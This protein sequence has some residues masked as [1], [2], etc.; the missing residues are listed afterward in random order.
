M[1]VQGGSNFNALVK[2]LRRHADSEDEKQQRPGSPG[3]KN[4]ASSPKK[5]DKVRYLLAPKTMAGT[6]AL[7]IYYTQ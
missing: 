7:R 5:F 2:A 1:L 3:R 4:G 6:V